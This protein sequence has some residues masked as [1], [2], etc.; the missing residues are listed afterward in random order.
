MWILGL[1]GLIVYNCITSSLLC[2]SF[3]FLRVGGHTVDFSH[4]KCSIHF[5]SNKR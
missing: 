1:K 2:V 5:R 3:L 4:E